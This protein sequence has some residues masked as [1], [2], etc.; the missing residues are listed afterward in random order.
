M[1][2][3]PREN[4]YYWLQAHR[5]LLIIVAILLAIGVA[6][7]TVVNQS[8]KS[9]S[10]FVLT[11]KLNRSDLRVTAILVNRSGWML[12]EVQSTGSTDSGNTAYAIF[13]KEK[14]VTTLKLGPGT[15]FTKNSLQQIGMPKDIQDEVAKKLGQ[16]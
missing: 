9:T 6:A 14:D 3:N 12:V 15:Y 7:I 4:M 10:E 5:K 8:Q 2:D 1:M 16:G 11:K 13:Y